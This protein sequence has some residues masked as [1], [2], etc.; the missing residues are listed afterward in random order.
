MYSALE[1]TKCTPHSLFRISE[2]LRSKNFQGNENWK[3]HLNLWK[4]TIKLWGGK[5]DVE[6]TKGQPSKAKVKAKKKQIW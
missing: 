2:A 5:L 1:F 4:G 3:Q 6:T